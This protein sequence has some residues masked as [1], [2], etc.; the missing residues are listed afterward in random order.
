[1]SQKITLKGENNMT[2][3]P[4]INVVNAPNVTL[5]NRKAKRDIL[6][7]D[8]EKPTAINL[9]H[10]TNIFIEGKKITFQYQTTATYIEL[11]DDDA[12]SYVFQSILN[13]WAGED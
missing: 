10:V 4:A 11:L 2:T 12:A 9:E 8:G 7:F 6:R 13:F 1:M 5:P 3:K